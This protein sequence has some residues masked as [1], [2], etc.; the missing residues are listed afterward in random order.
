MEFLS[1]YTILHFTEWSGGDFKILDHK[2]IN[3]IYH[4]HIFALVGTTYIL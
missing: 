3:T 1:K 2:T 4:I